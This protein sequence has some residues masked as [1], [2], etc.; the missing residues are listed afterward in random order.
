VSG[1]Y[2]KNE[3]KNACL[4][5]IDCCE[6]TRYKKR[7]GPSMRWLDYTEQDAQI[8]RIKGWNTTALDKNQ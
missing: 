5:D 7:R 2:V 4:Q 6:M 3:D 1:I 8:L